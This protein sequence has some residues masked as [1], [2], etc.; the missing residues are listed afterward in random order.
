M[1]AQLGVQM[2]KEEVSDRLTGAA[3][4]HISREVKANTVGTG[5]KCAGYF[6]FVGSM[7]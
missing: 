4:V 2:P 7:R 1:T 3:L 5:D 6:G